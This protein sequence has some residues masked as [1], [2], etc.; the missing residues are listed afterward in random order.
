MDGSRSTDLSAGGGSATKQL[1]RRARWTPIVLALA[2]AV[3]LAVVW[4]WT[5]IGA[6]VRPERLVEFAEP[7]RSSWFALPLV[8]VVFVLAELVLFPVL[9]LVFVCGVAFGPWLGALYALTGSVASAIPPFLIG[10]KLGG[11]RLERLGGAPVRKIA[12]V[13]ERRGLMAVFLVRKIPAPFTLVNLICGAAQVT[14][15]DFVLGTL[16]GMGT[17]VIVITILGGRLIELWHDPEPGSIALALGLL[18]LPAL[19]AWLIQRAFNRRAETR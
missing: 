9:V 12:R 11:Q 6:H 3:L 17:G 13:L 5:P 10:R 7:W 2:A 16:L 1:S 15:Q 4:K 8:V 19:V 18:M 14:L